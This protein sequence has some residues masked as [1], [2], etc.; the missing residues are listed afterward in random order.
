M[1]LN[2]MISS[3][4]EVPYFAASRES[5]AKDSIIRGISRATSSSE[6]SLMLG[7]ILMQ[8]AL[9]ASAASSKSLRTVSDVRNRHEVG[10]Q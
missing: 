9:R 3:A 8:R 6:G 2:G 1:L 4:I 10:M 7:A 5:A